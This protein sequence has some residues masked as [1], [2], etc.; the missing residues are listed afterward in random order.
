[1]EA[2][3]PVNEPQRLEAL[4]AYQIL[5]T[6][7][8]AAFDDLA[9]LAAQV[10]G[11]SIA[12]VSLLDGDRV[13]FKA[14]VG[15]DCRQVAR[16]DSVCAYAVLPGDGPMVVPD[17]AADP[18]FAGGAAMTGPLHLRSYAGVRLV[19]A[20]GHVV[21]VLCV[22][23]QKPCWLSDEKL[24]VLRILARQAM[25]LL[26]FHRGRAEAQAVAEALRQREAALAD[27]MKLAQLGGWEHD[28]ATDVVTLS[29][30]FF[31]LAGTSGQQE[32][33]ATL[34]MDV[35]VTRFVP[36]EDWPVVA[37]ERKK[38]KQTSD[39][40]YIGQFEHRLIRRDGG[41][42][43]LRVRYRLVGNAGGPA[44]KVCGVSQDIT[45]QKQVENELMESK[46]FLQAT[47][48]ALTAHIA[49]L[50]DQGVVIAVNSAWSRFAVENGFLGD[51]HGLGANYMELCATA[52]G[53]FSEEASAMFQG[54]RAVMAGQQPDFLIE[55]PCHGPQEQRWFEARVTRFGGEGPVRVVVAHQDITVRKRAEE[56]L[57][58]KTALLEAQMDSSLEGVLVVDK[59]GRKTLQNERANELF[60]MPRFV[61]ENLDDEQQVRWVAEQVADSAG[62]LEKVRFLFAHTSETYRD[63]LE[64]K[65]GRVLDRYTAPLWGKNG[66][67]F[68]RVWTFRDVTEQ[69]HNEVSL[70]ESEEH[71]RSL[72][73]HG[74]TA[75][76]LVSPAGILLHVNDAFCR[77]VRRSGGALIG[78]KGL[79][80]TH[81]DDVAHTLECFRRL[82]AGEKE[83]Q[84]WEKRYRTG[85]GGVLWTH[86][87]ARLLRDAKGQPLHFLVDILDITERKRAEEN[88]KERLAL[89]GRLAK[90]AANVPGIIYTFRLRPDGSS[91]FPYISPTAYEFFGV[92]A[93]QIV[94]DGACAFERVHP[95]D[96]PRVRESI[97]ESARN[98]A[99]WRQEFRVENRRKEGFFWL[100][101]QSTPEREGDGSVLWHGFMSDISERKHAAE[102]LVQAK[103][104]ADSANLAKSEFLATMS[105][106][107]RTPMNGLLGFAELLLDTPLSQEQRQFVDTIRFS[108][109][110][111][112]NLI[113]D[114]LDF[115]K[116]EAG[117]LEISKRP[118]GLAGVVEEVVGLLGD[119]ARRKGLSLC[120]TYDPTKPQ[121]AVG[122]PDRVR[123]VLLNL[124]GNAIK[125]TKQGAVSVV[126]LPPP[127]SNCPSD[128]F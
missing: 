91:C 73:E 58:R 2:Q 47:L 118:F 46:R 60:K 28:L 23:D 4:R 12:A 64:L 3:L 37:E 27:A 72:F 35:M 52:A 8:E 124:V 16:A 78:M 63:E 68:G 56:E 18:R 94:G 62:F 19:S 95:E 125:F 25:Q 65:D 54:I 99:P 114:I 38:V 30:H 42:R 49:I 20:D 79:D 76:C 111:L 103:E 17:F 109:T 69:R 6:P 89:Q 55:Y 126:L 119:Q 33:G 44:V 90:I 101:G 36:P 80:L 122:D 40:G 92:R 110:T 120:A 67:Y 84:E 86:V 9:R 61:A 15:L 53:D 100:E 77:L 13:W 7:P 116:I 128:E 57:Q 105:H 87:T 31:A 107:I 97:L 1:M 113:N 81:A 96:L 74:P 26:E 14:R 70:R 45:V 98:V 43:H 83:I 102:Q 50:D 112:L 106:E 41:R 121:R 108:G 39:P 75:K 32:G 34:A 21:G 71:F 10:C 104:A 115:S 117:K 85:D 29:D 123:Q 127:R 22:M 82:L 66:Q 5:D 51:G 88:L 11:T 24:E 48:D 93:E 59:T